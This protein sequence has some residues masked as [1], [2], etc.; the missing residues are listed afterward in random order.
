MLMSASIDETA[1]LAVKLFGDPLRAEIVGHLAA[2]QLCPC[3][4]VEMTGAR[5]PTVSHHLKVLRDADLVEA[6]P[7]GRFTYYR[8]RPER[9]DEVRHGLSKLA[10]AASSA[11]RR[12]RPCE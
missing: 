12:R 8:L 4:L 10:E 7:D 6:I 1:D 11:P 5:Q 9:L 3:H 2:E